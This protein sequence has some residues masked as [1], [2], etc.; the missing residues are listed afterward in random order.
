MAGLFSRCLRAAG[1][2]RA[3]RAPGHELPAPA[4][5][6]VIDV[7]AA[8]LAVLLADADGRLAG[9][10]APRPGLALLPG[11]RIRLSSQPGEE[12]LAQPVLEPSELPAAVAGWTV[13]RV[14]AALELDVD[15]DLD[16]PRRTAWSHWPSGPP[17]TGW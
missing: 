1:V 3:F 2:T 6:D 13:G 16:A 5:I 7:P 10:P 11:R 14:H 12:V 15:V 9:A 17:T 8:E 4:G